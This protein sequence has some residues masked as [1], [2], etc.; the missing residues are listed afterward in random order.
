M[1][2]SSSGGQWSFLPWYSVKPIY[3]L[4][5]RCVEIEWKLEWLRVWEPFSGGMKIERPAQIPEI[6]MSN[7]EPYKFEFNDV[8][9]SS[10]E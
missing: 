8:E 1:K 9:S 2:E 6:D 7:V 5:G 10:K 4:D 3:D